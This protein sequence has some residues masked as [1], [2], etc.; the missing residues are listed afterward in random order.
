MAGARE[1]KPPAK[2]VSSP[3]YCAALTVYVCVN[4]ASCPAESF[5]V[6]VNTL[7][8]SVAVSSGA[9]FSTVPL[10]NVIAALRLGATE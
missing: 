4:S 10:R 1:M 8:P 2:A 5:A 9:P 6:T 3:S 7:S